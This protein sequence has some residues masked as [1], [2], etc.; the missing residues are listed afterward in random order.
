MYDKVRTPPRVGMLVSADLAG[1]DKVRVLPRV[2]MLISADPCGAAGN[3][4]KKPVLSAA[5]C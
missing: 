5:T 4:S 2:G 1:S 3:S